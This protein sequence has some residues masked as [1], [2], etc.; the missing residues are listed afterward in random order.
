MIGYEVRFGVLAYLGGGRGGYLISI[1]T[2]AR[3]RWHGK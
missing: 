3:C 2:L 1:C